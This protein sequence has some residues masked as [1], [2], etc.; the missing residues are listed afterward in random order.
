M[1][2]H[3]FLVATILSLVGRIDGTY[4]HHVSERVGPRAWASEL[5]THI[6]DAAASYGVD[7]WLLTALY[8]HESRFY[9]RARSKQGARGISQINPK[10]WP[11][12]WRAIEKA[13]KAERSRLQVFHGASILRHYQKKCGANWRAVSGYRSGRCSKHKSRNT[14]KVM[15][16]YRLIERARG[17]SVPLKAGERA[18]S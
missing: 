5:A 18:A 17:P 15:S 8:Y 4:I 6:E 3:A 7:P 2:A 10:A 9:E 11:R 13:P 1:T 12:K 16:T 14:R